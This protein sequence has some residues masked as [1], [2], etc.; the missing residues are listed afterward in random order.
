MTAVTYEVF[1]DLLIGNFMKTTLHNL[2][3]L[4]P[5]FSPIVAK[6]ADNGRAQT[7]AELRRYMWEYL[8]RAPVS[9]I[10]SQLEDESERR[11]RRFVSR[12]SLMFNVAAR[13]YVLFKRLLHA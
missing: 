5:V 4:Y 1:D 3:N 2:K 7:R 8:R 13:G 10:I 11:F 6:Y 12:D 9:F